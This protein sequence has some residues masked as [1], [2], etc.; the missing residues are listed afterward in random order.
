MVSRNQTFIW[1]EGTTR[2]SFLSIA[3]VR[4]DITLVFVLVPPTL[5]YLFFSRLGLL[6][7]SPLYID[8]YK[9][10]CLQVFMDS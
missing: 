5:R 2:N 10:Q 6:D 8:A 9:A 1:S 4:H 3:Y 7:S